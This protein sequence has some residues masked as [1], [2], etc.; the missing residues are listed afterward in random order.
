MINHEHLVST[1]AYILSSEGD[2]EAQMTRALSAIGNALG[3]SRVY[4]IVYG[5][6]GSLSEHVHEWRSHGIPSRIEAVTATIF[7][8]IPEW[9]ALLASDELVFV[10]HASTLAPAVRTLLADTNV[11]SMAISALKQDG[12]IAGF[13]GFDECAVLL[14]LVRMINAKKRAG[15]SAVL[16]ARVSPIASSLIQRI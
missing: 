10:D 6:D 14:A 3:L 12:R 13:M 9:N 16:S 5:P 1:V 8:G 4:V 7:S 2:H 11:A 15:I